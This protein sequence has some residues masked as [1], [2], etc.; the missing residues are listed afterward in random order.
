MNPKLNFKQFTNCLLPK[1]NNQLFLPFWVPGQHSTY[2][3]H[4]SN[5]NLFAVSQI[6]KIDQWCFFQIWR[7]IKMFLNFQNFTS[8][9]L[10]NPKISLVFLI[11]PFLIRP[12]CVY[13]P[14]TVFISLFLLRGFPLLR[15]ILKKQRFHQLFFFLFFIITEGSFLFITFSSAFV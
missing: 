9:V 1:L 13:V 15:V 14:P 11:R 12:Y 2:L 4:L 7:I 10:K 6:E 8:H 5:K 3:H